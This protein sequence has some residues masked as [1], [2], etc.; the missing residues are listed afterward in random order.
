M[1]RKPLGE[2]GRIIAMAFKFSA[3]EKKAIEDL[4]FDLDLTLS[5]VIR[6]LINDGIQSNLGNVKHQWAWTPVQ[7]CREWDNKFLEEIGCPKFYEASFERTFKI[8]N[9]EEEMLKYDVDKKV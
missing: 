8:F 9:R 1:G 6:M 4:A 2:K 3:N 7:G 5:E